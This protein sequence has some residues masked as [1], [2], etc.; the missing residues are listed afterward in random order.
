VK[1]NSAVL[2]PGKLESKFSREISVSFAKYEGE[3]ILSVE[4]EVHGAEGN[5]RSSFDPVA[6][7]GVML[8]LV[9][10]NL[11]KTVHILLTPLRSSLCQRLEIRNRTK[12]R[13]AKT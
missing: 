10:G 6:L 12:M 8:I 4:S 9:R 7:A 5:T 1:F 2:P 3:T 13:Q 11:L